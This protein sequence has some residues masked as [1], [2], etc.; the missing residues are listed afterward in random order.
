MVKFDSQ[1]T[2]LEVLEFNKYRPGFLNRQI[3]IL[4]STL[5]VPNKA[6]KKLQEENIKDLENCNLKDANIYRYFMS[7]SSE[8]I[9]IE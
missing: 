4:L 9:E 8:T 5:G 7:E 3:I 2:D 6:F 1:P